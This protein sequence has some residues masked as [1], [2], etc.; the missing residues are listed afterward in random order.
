MTYSQISEIKLWALCGMTIEST[1][2]VEYVSLVEMPALIRKRNWPSFSWVLSVS[3][4]E[5][6]PAFPVCLET[7]VQAFRHVQQ[8][9]NSRDSQLWFFHAAEGRRK[10]SV[11]WDYRGYWKGQC[12]TVLRMKKGASSLLRFMRSFWKLRWPCVWKTQVTYWHWKKLLNC[13]EIWSSQKIL[14]EWRGLMS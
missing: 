14:Q 8:V 11:Y 5:E 12:R 6:N 4:P 9:V 2:E 1:T 7:S 10:I 3:A 13:K